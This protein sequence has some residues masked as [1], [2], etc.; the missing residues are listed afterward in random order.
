MVEIFT[1]YGGGIP[2]PS[3]FTSDMKMIGGGAPFTKM[4]SD[5]HCTPIGL[6]VRCNAYQ[7]S[8]IE[9]DNFHVYDNVQETI[10]Q[11]VIPDDLWDNL[12]GKVS[13]YTPTK[14]HTVKK[15]PLLRSNR[16]HKTRRSW[17]LM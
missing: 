3:F 7:I 17:S 9:A 16:R 12:I 13:Y 11:S 2:I 5:S 10:E 1:E 4:I 14:R 8:D 15:Y 6:G